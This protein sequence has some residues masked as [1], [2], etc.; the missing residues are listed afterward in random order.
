MFGKAT[1][2]PRMVSTVPSSCK[3]LSSLITTDRE[4]LS[5]SVDG[6]ERVVWTYQSIPL[7]TCIQTAVPRGLSLFIHSIALRGVHTAPAQN[8]ES[9]LPRSRSMPPVVEMTRDP[10]R[11]LGRDSGFVNGRDLPLLRVRPEWKVGGRLLRPSRN[12]R[13]VGGIWSQV[14]GIC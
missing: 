11:R 2:R 6:N 14:H 4:G 1:E 5:N 7:E 13:D 3:Y 9:R 12:Y 10:S 8:S